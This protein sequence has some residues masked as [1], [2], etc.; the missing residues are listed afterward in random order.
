MCKHWNGTRGS[1][2]LTPKLGGV[3]QYEAKEEQKCW[4]KC[5]DTQAIYTCP[6]FEPRY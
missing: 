2:T 5:K 3:Y 4:V 6:K 1:D